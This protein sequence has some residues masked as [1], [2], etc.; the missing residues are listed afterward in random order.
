MASNQVSVKVLPEYI[1]EESN[2]SKKRY[3]FAY[4]VIIENLGQAPAQLMSRHWIITNGET[5]KTQEV[6]GDGVVGQQPRIE[7]GEH[8][9][10]TSGTVLE[11]P[12]GTMQGSYKMVDDDGEFFEVNIPVFTLAATNSVH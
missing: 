5:L 9:E 2:P 3:V 11:S 4:T 1:P 6:Q 8:F 10:Y 12:V 7:P